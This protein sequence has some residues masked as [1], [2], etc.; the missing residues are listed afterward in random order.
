VTHQAIEAR[1]ARHQLE[2]ILDTLGQPWPWHAA[3]SRLI[4]LWLCVEEAA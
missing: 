2:E 3:L 4:D 1:A